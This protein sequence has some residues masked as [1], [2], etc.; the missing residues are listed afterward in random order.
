[1]KKKLASVL[2]IGIFTTGII[3]LA[4]MIVNTNYTGMQLVNV[5]LK[6]WGIA[7]ILVIP[8]ILIISPLVDKVINK[9]I[10]E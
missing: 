3:S 7:Y 2:L 4:L 9:L 6:S 10:K 1:M 5:W 8:C